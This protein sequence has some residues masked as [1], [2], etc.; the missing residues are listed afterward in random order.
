MKEIF[1]EMA[2]TMQVGTINERFI[3]IIIWI[4]Q[5]ANHEFF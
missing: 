3:N 4:N 2:K 5:N 1:L